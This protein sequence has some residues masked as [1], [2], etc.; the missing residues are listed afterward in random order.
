[1]ALVKDPSIYKTFR[2]KSTVDTVELENWD[3]K[4]TKIKKNPLQNAK[5]T[6]ITVA[7]RAV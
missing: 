4:Q 3:K 6:S 7:L 1:M 2:K 5:K